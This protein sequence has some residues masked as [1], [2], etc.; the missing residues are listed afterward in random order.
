MPDRKEQ[1]AN[2]VDN[3]RT[4]NKGMVKFGPSFL[5][6]LDVTYSQMIILGL[7]K[8][9]EGISLKGLAATLGISS[10]AATQQVNT[11]VKRGYLV[12]QESDADRRLVKIRLSGEMDKRVENIKARFLEQI[13]AFFDRMSDEELAQ[14]SALTAKIAS[15]V[16]Q[17]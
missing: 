3:F 7:V 1:I 12:R 14:Y 10:S 4:I 8:E 2:L 16:L 11:L 6:E 9:N 13:S 5:N 17:E 15:Q